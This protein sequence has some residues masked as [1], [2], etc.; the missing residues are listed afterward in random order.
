MWSR[1]TSPDRNLFPSRLT[2][3]IV[4]FVKVLPVAVYRSETCV[5]L[6]FEVIQKSLDILSHKNSP[7]HC[8]WR[9]RYD[10]CRSIVN[11]RR[12]HFN[13]SVAS[14][15]LNHLI[16]PLQHLGRDRQADLLRG[17]E[18][19]DEL[20]LDRLLDGKVGGLGELAT[21]FQHRGKRNAVL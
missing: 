1:V 14:W 13:P 21:G 6:A 9:A 4:D 10:K 7:L 19:D 18:I 17:F 11:W 20:E 15:L 2:R 8:F 12:N 16:R 5:F 3:V